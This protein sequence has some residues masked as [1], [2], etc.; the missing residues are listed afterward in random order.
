MRAYVVLHPH[1]T[2]P[3]LQHKHAQGTKQDILERWHSARLSASAFTNR[4]A[5]RFLVAASQFFSS[6][7]N[8]SLKWLN[9]WDNGIGEIAEA[10]SRER[11]GKT[12]ATNQN[13]HTEL[14]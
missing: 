2:S 7:M 14:T 12:S 4:N 5:R 1:E 11:R 3:R 9:S 8:L 13:E 6:S 10:G